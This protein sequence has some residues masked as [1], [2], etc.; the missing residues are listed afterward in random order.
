MSTAQQ[1]TETPAEAAPQTSSSP[2]VTG[3]TTA[4]PAAGLE[5]EVRYHDGLQAQKLI[6]CDS[7]LTITGMLIPLLVM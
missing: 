5:A 6:D 7:R 3:V 4:G 1:P 2:T